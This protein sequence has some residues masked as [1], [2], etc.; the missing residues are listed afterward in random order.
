MSM[1]LLK[2]CLPSPRKASWAWVGLLGCPIP[3]TLRVLQPLCLHCQHRTVP[4][5]V[6]SICRSSSWDELCGWRGLLHATDFKPGRTVTQR[7]AASSCAAALPAT[8]RQ[9]LGRNTLIPSLGKG[10]EV[11]FETSFEKLKFYVFLSLTNT[12]RRTS[13]V[14]PAPALLAL[15][16]DGEGGG[17]HPGKRWMCNETE[18]YPKTSGWHQLSFHPPADI[19]MRGCSRY[20][21]FR[22]QV[23]V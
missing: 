20:S 3:R 6:W 14:L 18:L 21:D 2:K 7:P 9:S 1:M 15:R 23:S 12:I 8:H 10:S 5:A 19:A 4:M 22:L 16:A 17:K 13:C 11:S